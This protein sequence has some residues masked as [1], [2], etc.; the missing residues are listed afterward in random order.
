MPQQKPCHFLTAEA[1]FEHWTI[2]IVI[3]L[4]LESLLQLCRWYV[5]QCIVN[6]TVS[7][8]L[9]QINVSAIAMHMTVF[10]V[11]VQ[12]TVSVITGR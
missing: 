9:M 8:V 10:I 11:T 4:E 5:L 6:M 2:F 3:M 1:N 7:V 12:I